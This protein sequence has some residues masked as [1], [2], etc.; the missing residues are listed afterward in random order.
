MRDA[1]GR[2][3]E[4]GGDYY[5][6][7][8]LLAR[9]LQ[10]YQYVAGAERLE[11]NARDW[12]YG[13]PVFLGTHRIGL[14]DAFTVGG[15][16]EASS[17]MTS[18]GP[19]AVARLGRFGEVEGVLGVSGGAPGAG[20]A[21]SVSYL[22]MGRAFSAGGAWR[23]ADR[24]YRTAS[25]VS[26]PVR[27]R[28][29]LDAGA[30]ASTRLGSRVSS[31]L[32]WQRQEY[33]S[34][35][36]RIDRL[37]VTTTCRVAG[38]SE[39]YATFSRTDAGGRIAPGVFIGLTTAVGRRGTVGASVEH[40]DRHTVVAVD[41]QRSLPV[42][43]GYGYRLRG[44]GGE[45]GALDADVQ[46]QTRFGRYEVRQSQFD[47]ERATSLSASGAIVGIGGRVFASRPVEQSYGLVRV[48]G[49]SNVRAF[50]SHQEVGRTDR[51]GDILVPNLLPYY[52]NVLTIA[53]EDVPLDLTITRRE[54]TLAPPS[55][56]GALALFPVKREVRVTGRLVVNAHGDEIVPSFGRLVVTGTEGSLESPIG[57]KGEFY[58]EG[59]EPGAHAG[60]VEFEHR[61]CAFTLVV[62]D[63]PAAVVQLGVV[64]CLAE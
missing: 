16:L 45:V 53:D 25:D 58:I 42:G 13:R 30:M 6:T 46:Y 23:H 56:G 21:W 11:P 2:E 39:L 51:H 43:E 61:S 8:S 55:G 22:Y 17:S 18:G 7:T 29:S 48:P 36:P 38:S 37:S 32:T 35:Y 9:G 40:V 15:R 27:P 19:Q 28:L 63:R 12:A 4:I 41:A 64:Q 10:Q 52:G 34:L 14:T 5:V 50:V 1:F 33:H 49:V 24:A 44:Q 59:L 26:V 3:Q 47:G 31:T 20:H 60:R 54:M 57:A 62:P